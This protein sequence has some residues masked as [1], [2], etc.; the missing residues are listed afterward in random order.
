MGAAS[1]RS[2]FLC[3][4]L[5]LIARPSRFGFRFTVLFSFSGRA[6]SGSPAR[7][8][9][10][11]GPWPDPARPWRVPPG[12]SP[13]PGPLSSLSHFLFP[14]S[15]LSL[16]LFHHSSTSLT[17][18]IRCDPM[19]GCRRSSDPKVSFPSPLLSPSFPFPLSCA[20]PWRLALT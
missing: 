20:R 18:A 10:W 11:P 19:D 16:P 15:N 5:C 14:R 13:P 9:V 2:I 8:A 7:P 1:C 12:A 4:M 17:L 3:L 6:C